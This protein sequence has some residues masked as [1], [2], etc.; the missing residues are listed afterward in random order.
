MLRVNPPQFPFDVEGSTTGVVVGG[1]LGPVICTTTGELKDG[2][3]V[4]VGRAH[5]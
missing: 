3:P 1:S 4:I 5:A 2:V